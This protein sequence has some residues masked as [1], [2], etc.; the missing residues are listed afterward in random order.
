MTLVAD[1]ESSPL[2]ISVY[3]YKQT[4]KPPKASPHMPINLGLVSA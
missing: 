2:N 4:K 3:N 1:T